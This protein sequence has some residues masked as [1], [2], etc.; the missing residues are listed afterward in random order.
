MNAELSTRRFGEALAE[1]TKT[2]YLDQS[3]SEFSGAL[4]L[5]TSVLKNM[6]QE[7]TEE[8]FPV[9]HLNRMTIERVQR[10]S[11]GTTARLKNENRQKRTAWLEEGKTGKDLNENL[12]DL[13]PASDT[14]IT[15][16][17][18]KR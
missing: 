18:K 17:E 15:I 7:E 9:Q 6:E 10:S 3:D 16:K 4:N 12:N 1:S 13:R 5:K 14:D 8:L 11:P 2:T